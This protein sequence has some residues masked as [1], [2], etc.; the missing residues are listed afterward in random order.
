M[1][2]DYDTTVACLYATF[3][4]SMLYALTQ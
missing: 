3:K 4:R 1:I 2:S